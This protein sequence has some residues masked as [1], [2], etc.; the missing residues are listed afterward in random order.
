MYK[1]LDF[2]EAHA[3]V[4]IVEIGLDSRGAFSNS[5]VI[6]WAILADWD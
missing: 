6:V 1:L 3:S 5:N 4:C 2:L